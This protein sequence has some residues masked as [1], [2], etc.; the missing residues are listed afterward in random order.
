M[1]DPVAAA[2]AANQI[3]WGTVVPWVLGAVG[4]TA[5]VLSTAFT[6]VWAA[7][8][9]SQKELVESHKARA[10]S[11]E[12]RAIAAEQ[13]RELAEQ[14]YAKLRGE[15]KATTRALGLAV[16]QDEEQRFGTALSV[17]PPSDDDPT[18]RFYVRADKYRE[19]VEKRDQEERDRQRSI[20]HQTHLRLPPPSKELSREALALEA[21]G[22]NPLPN[23]KNLPANAGREDHRAWRKAQDQEGIVTPEQP[24][25]P[26]RERQRSYRRD[27]D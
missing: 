4:G 14:C 1:A 5:T 8:K 12:T 18:I 3:P 10:L 24:V 2:E 6:A 19:S 16:R 11:A 17:P 27:D 23:K 21:F 9:N 26:H 25:V 15:F 22:D 20:G 13:G 7:Y